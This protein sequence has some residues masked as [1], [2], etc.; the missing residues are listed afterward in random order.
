MDEY[1]TKQQAW[2]SMRRRL[3]KRNASVSRMASRIRHLESLFADIA[4]EAGMPDSSSPEKVAER[5][6]AA[7]HTC[8]R[9]GS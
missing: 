5:A 7:I 9:F 6:R 3:R 4:E 2:E 8:K 1:P